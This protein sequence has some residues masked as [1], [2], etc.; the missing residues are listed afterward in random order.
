MF[1]EEV[2]TVK[3]CSGFGGVGEEGLVLVGSYGPPQ[4][5]PKTPDGVGLPYLK[6]I[7]NTTKSGGEDGYS[8]GKPHK[9]LN[10]D[11]NTDHHSDDKLIKPRDVFCGHH[12]PP[13]PELTVLCMF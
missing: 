11:G 10:G 5:S 9:P 1:V 4:L 6:S 8:R 7:P 12:A 13:P 2:E 3:G